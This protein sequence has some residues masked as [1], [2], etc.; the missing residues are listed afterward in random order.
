MALTQI[1]T[2][3]IKD[4]TITGSD[5]ATNVDLV[6]NQKLRFGTGNDLEIYHNG[7]GSYIKDTG[8]GQLSI[9]SNVTNIL[10]AAGNEYC[11]RFIEDGAV[12]LYHNG[13]EK[14][15]TTSG[16]VQV[17]DNLNMSG[18]HIFLA[19]NYK[20][21]VGTGDD[22][23]IYHD[24]SHSYID[25]TTTGDLY[26]RSTNDDIIMSAADDIVLQVQ[27]SETGLRCNGNGAVELYYDNS[28]KFETSS[29]GT[30]TTGVSS[31]TSLSINS[32]SGYIG[33]PDSAKIF[34]GTGNDLQIYHDGSNSYIYQNGTGE[35]RI[36]TNTFRVMDRNG[37]ETQIVASEDG[38]VELYYDNSKKLHTHSGGITISGSIHMDDN[39]KFICG[40]SDDLQIYHNGTNSFIQDVGTGG[41][42]VIT[43]DFAVN[44]A[45][46]TE[47][48]IRAVENSSVQLFFDG[49]LRGFTHSSGWR[50]N[51]SC[52]PNGDG[53]SAMNLGLSNER[54]HTVFAIT[55]TINTSDER[56][57]TNINATSLGLDFINKLKPV[58]YN[59][60]DESRSKKLHYGLVVQDIIKVLEEENI[61]LNDFGAINDEG[62]FYGLN[63]SEFISPLIKA[64]QELS[65]EVAALKAS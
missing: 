9:E 35:L 28:K 17:T 61:E 34:V 23:Q 38:A 6:D 41:I 4:G 52:F 18:G 31:T 56:E 53:N 12:K 19:D 62:K 26:L 5:L 7:S 63:Y 14:F 40:T 44:N 10:N 36:N 59:W 51:G 22:L 11:A 32:T 8:T 57:K 29:T 48:M 42:A 54:W 37:G 24:G 58:T 25:G 47:Q 39:N 49:G 60:K 45:A 2:K 3:G 50:V 15:E 1:S 27:G 33:L 64:V 55:G 43:N 21:N 16:G 20:L 46:D 13:N 30:T 65:A